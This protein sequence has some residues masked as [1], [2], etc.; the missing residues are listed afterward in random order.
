MINKL[1]N[2]IG[3]L[4]LSAVVLFVSMFGYMQ[5]A[6]ANPSFFLRNNTSSATAV[7]SSVATSSQ[8][9]YQTAGT[10]TSTIVLNGSINSNTAI[11]SATLIL[12]RLTVG[13]TSRTVI[14][15]EES[16]NCDAT[17]PDWYQV[18][19][20]ASSSVGRFITGSQSL[21]WQFAS[22]TVGDSK[23]TDYRD[24]LAIS[25]PVNLKCVRAIIAVPPDAASSTIYGELIGKRQGN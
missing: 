5:F 15:F 12:H 6:S 21:S 20:A 1:I 9:A 17:A 4:A 18:L 10:A 19:S 14:S 3:L 24:T 11:D 23:V 25:V 22:S 2:N 7:A 16:M 8:L 13:N